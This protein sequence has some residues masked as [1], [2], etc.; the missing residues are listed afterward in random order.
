MNGQQLKTAM[1]A[2]KTVM[3]TMLNFACVARGAT[4][5]GQ[6]GLDFA[7]VDAEHSPN[8]R[9]ELADMGA[10]LLAAG[11]CPVT[12]VPHTEPHP[13]ISRRNNLPT[14]TARARASCCSARTG[15]QWARGT[16]AHSVAFAARRSG[17]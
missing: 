12:R 1:R 3:G 2:G 16:A 13:T 8:G 5:F 4:L 17:R 15:G 9:S 6:L 10:A 11:V 14:G 7:I